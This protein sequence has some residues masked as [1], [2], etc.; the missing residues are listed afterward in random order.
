[1]AAGKKTARGRKQDQARVAAGQ[2]YEVRYETKKT[3][4]SASAVKKAVKKVG[5]SR[6]R[7]GKSLGRRSHTRWRRRGWPSIRAGTQGRYLRSTRALRRLQQALRP[8]RCRTADLGGQCRRPL[9]RV[10]VGAVPHPAV[11]LTFV[12]GTGFPQHGNRPSAQRAD[13]GPSLFDHQHRDL[14]PA[15]DESL[16]PSFVP[17]ANTRLGFAIV[18]AAGFPLVPP[19]CAKRQAAECNHFYASPF[20]FR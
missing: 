12:D 16:R 14:T 13:G 2:D 15:R 19:A 10:R 11:F 7:V 6:K 20:L 4:R 3:G 17:A 5:N 8:A 18:G 1:M 9:A